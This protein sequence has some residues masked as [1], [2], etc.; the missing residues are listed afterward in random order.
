M[1][2][3]WLRV[4]YRK[5]L[6]FCFYNLQKIA[7]RYLQNN[8]HRKKSKTKTLFIFMFIY[9]LDN[10]VNVTNCACMLSSSCTVSR[11]SKHSK[12]SS[13]SSWFDSS[14]EMIL[15]C[16]NSFTFKINLKFSSK[17]NLQ[18][19]SIFDSLISYIRWLKK[20]TNFDSL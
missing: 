9:R 11:V 5:K 17:Q 2:N 10:N 8:A 14:W 15:I 12:L 4:A 3:K 19:K 16:S 6:P 20:R 1:I 7:S 18:L 13:I